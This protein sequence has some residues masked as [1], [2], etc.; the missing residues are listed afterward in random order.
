MRTATMRLAMT[1]IRICEMIDT[2]EQCSILARWFLIAYIQ[3]PLNST[4]EWL[5]HLTHQRTQCYTMLRDHA[6]V[7]IQN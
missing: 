7:T 6:R 3:A 2:E 1:L 5:T 4:I